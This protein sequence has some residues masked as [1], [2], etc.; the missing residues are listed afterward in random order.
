MLFIDICLLL[1]LF[2]DCREKLYCFL[3][4]NT[5][6]EVMQAASKGNNTKK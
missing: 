1:N 4:L 3:P 6:P 2:N 5:P